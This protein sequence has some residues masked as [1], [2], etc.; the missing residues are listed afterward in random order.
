MEV[1]SIAIPGQPAPI[2]KK[3][4]VE[5]QKSQSVKN[6]KTVK[7]SSVAIEEKNI[8]V[9]TP[10]GHAAN[11]GETTI[12]NEDNIGETTI[13]SNETQQQNRI[14]P[15][16]IRIKNNEKI[17]INK[18]VFRIGKERNYVDYFI[19]D[20]T[21][22]SRSHANIVSHNGEYFLVDTNSTNHSFVNGKMISSNVE[23]KIE[24]GTKIMLANEIFEFKFY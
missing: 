17:F 14:V 10:K 13:L 20:N 23:V 21:A 12:L 19:S 3:K 6:T 15:H 9:V 8:P 7:K 1:G 24:H 16:L 22:I 18:A 2:V 4:S 5:Q 11:F